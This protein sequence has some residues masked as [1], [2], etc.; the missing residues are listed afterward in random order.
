[1]T[2]SRALRRALAALGVVAVA[3]LLLLAARH[4]DWRVAW[5]TARR[6]DVMPC[7]LG[8]LCSVAS[9]AAKGVRWWIML[10]A[11]GARAL[12]RAMR[13]TFAGAA[14]NALVVAQ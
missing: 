1:M 4:V 13:A 5:A 11:V 7:A 6:A 2:A 14:L 3:L 8:A 12:G 10:R 9:L